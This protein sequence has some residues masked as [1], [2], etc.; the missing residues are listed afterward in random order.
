[1]QKEILDLLI[2]IIA[3]SSLLIGAVALWVFYKGFKPILVD[4]NKFFDSM[5]TED[6]KR[7]INIRIKEKL[8]TFV[9]QINTKAQLRSTYLIKLS[10]KIFAFN[11]NNNNKYI[12]SYWSLQTFTRSWILSLI[13]LVVMIFVVGYVDLDKGILWQFVF[14]FV[15]YIYMFYIVVAEKISFLIKLFLFIIVIIFT[16]MLT[17]GYAIAIAGGIGIL[18][19]IANVVSVVIMR[20]SKIVS[21]NENVIASAVFLIFLVTLGVAMEVIFNS[22]TPLTANIFQLLPTLKNIS[23]TN[24]LTLFIVFFFIMPL[25]NALIDSLSLSVSRYE[26]QKLLNKTKYSFSFFLK[27][28][29]L[30]FLY[31]LGFKLLV[32]FVLYIGA[33]FLQ[34]TGGTFQVNDIDIYFNSIIKAIFQDSSFNFLFTGSTNTMITLMVSTTLLPTIIHFIT[35]LFNTIWAF[36]ANS[37]QLFGLF[38]RGNGIFFSAVMSVVFLLSLLLLFFIIFYMVGSPLK[39]IPVSFI[40]TL[41]G[42]A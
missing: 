14:L 35:V 1:M 4:F 27:I 36:L 12:F 17:N 3:S 20:V 28:S 25:S 11:T 15:I 6:D 19:A 7:N 24:M 37:I 30:D 2:P 21:T 42:V 33:I 22:D 40:N 34:N 31:A 26:F 5:F 41:Y 32:L 18:G 23:P 39:P 16:I 29:L 9:E 38:F 8:S 10:D 13:Y